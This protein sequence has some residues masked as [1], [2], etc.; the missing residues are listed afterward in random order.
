MAKK[1]KKRRKG[2]IPL[3]LNRISKKKRKRLVDY[4][5]KR[6]DV[7]VNETSHDLISGAL[8]DVSAEIIFP[9][10]TF[11]VDFNLKFSG[12]DVIEALELTKPKKK[13]KK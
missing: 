1:K 4:L 6:F 2:I 12:M 3:D 8:E 13:G 11:W 5:A 10:S 7:Y 9:T